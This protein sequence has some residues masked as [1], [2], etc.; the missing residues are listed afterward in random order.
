MKRFFALFTFVVLLASSTHA[1]EPITAPP[2]RD[3]DVWVQ[4]GDSITEQKLYSVY[5]EAFM[6]AR[7]PKMPFA[8]VHSGKSGQVYIQAIIRFRDTIAAYKP[9]LVT[10]NFDMNDHV[11]V[12]SGG[13]FQDDPINSP[14]RFIQS[15]QK[16]GARVVVLA[17]SPLLAAADYGQSVKDLLDPAVSKAKRDR[18]NPVNRLFADK[19]RIV[20]ERNNAPFLDQMAPLQTIWAANYTRDRIAALRT[21]L[22]PVLDIPIEGEAL[23][24]RAVAFD[25][26]VKPFL[27]SEA[28]LKLD[29][30]PDKEKLAAQWALVDGRKL[31][32]WE[33]FRQY[34]K[35]WAA[36]VDA[37]NP[38]FVQVSGYTRSVRPSDLIHPN[39]AGHLHMAGVILKQ[40]S[41]DGLV[42][43]V[44]IDATGKKLVAAQKATVRDIG[45]ANNV[46]SFKR[47]DESLPFP[48]DVAAR[49]ALGVDVESSTGNPKNLFGL[50]RYN[51]TVTG[52]PA[53]D[54]KLAIDGEEVATLSSAL[55]ARGADL[56]LLDKGPVYAQTQKLLLAVR[57]NLVDALVATTPEQIAAVTPVILPEA[58]P[59][60]HTW[61]LTPVK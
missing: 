4:V 12:F 10:V 41:A 1:A 33:V 14:Q 60:E 2:L 55:L 48:I 45:L 58:Q 16:A 22:I 44:T 40:M 30:L 15:A 7:Y 50:S 18:S 26:A 43:S 9:T 27:R 49:P 21:A 53:G 24:T 5:M 47:L 54:Y 42:S 38:P 3:G 57:A 52:L 46:L 29:I 56:G 13:D 6:R 51:L 20:A 19:L 28:F 37:S 39:E 23:N 32:T 11:K 17:A 35:T 25:N 31:E 59:V 61:T 36:Q 34:M 8:V